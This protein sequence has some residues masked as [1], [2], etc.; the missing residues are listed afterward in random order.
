M[1]HCQHHSRSFNVLTS[2]TVI[3]H[4]DKIV[5]LATAT[6]TIT[7]ATTATIAATATR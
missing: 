6:I 5:L 2:F 1:Q 7:V 3:T 4:S